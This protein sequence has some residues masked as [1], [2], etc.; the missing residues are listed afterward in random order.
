M[1]HTVNSR[2]VAALLVGAVLS[3][4]G[5]DKATGPEASALV[6]IP[7]SRQET[8]CA[9]FFPGIIQ[10]SELRGPRG[11]TITNITPGTYQ[12]RGTYDLT[13]SGVTGGVIELGF[14]GSVV[15][16]QN[17]QQAE[18]RPQTVSGT[19]TGSF[20]VVQGFLELTQGPGTPTVDFVVGSEVYDCVAL[21]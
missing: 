21:Y 5:G 6:N 8:W 4:C 17:G 14:L 13:G 2:A 19:L 3:S 20:E 12:A 11:A 16:G 18:S 15:T 10:V 7:F 9:G 1:V